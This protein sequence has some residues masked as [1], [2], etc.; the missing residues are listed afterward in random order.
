MSG[1]PGMMDVRLRKELMTRQTTAILTAGPRQ[2]GAW[3]DRAWR[4]ALTSQL[5]SGGS[6]DY[7]IATPTAPA[8]HPV[9]PAELLVEQPGREFLVD[10]I[11]MMLAAHLGDATVEGYLIDSGNIALDDTT[12]TIAPFWDVSAPSTRMYLARRMSEVVRVGIT[13]LDEFSPVTDEVIDELRSLGF[14]V[15]VFGLVSSSLVAAG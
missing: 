3:A 7:W 9:E 10:S 14:D 2:V 15:D 6:S 8:L 4:L 13:V 1:R 12:R 11:I 5:V